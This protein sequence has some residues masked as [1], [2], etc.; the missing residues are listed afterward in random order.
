M[1]VLRIAA[2][3]Q[4]EELA[5]AMFGTWGEW[6]AD[7]AVAHA[8]AWRP[9]VVVHERMAPFGTLVAGVLGVPCVRH[10]LGI[11]PGMLTGQLR[12]MSAALARHGMPDLVDDSPWIDIVPPS[13]A[14]AC[15][16]GWLMRSVPF[17]GGAVLPDWAVHPPERPRIAVTV[18]TLVGKRPDGIGLLERIMR[19]W[20]AVSV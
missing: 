19:S 14:P 2:G 16:D 13:L 12:H 5:G 15:R 6:A 8:E 17:N 18:G 4:S 3:D 1:R 9:D 20:R 11:E 7:G 10:D